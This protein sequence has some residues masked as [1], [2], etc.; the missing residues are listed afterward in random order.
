[1]ST[2]SAND[3]YT[4]LAEQL[5]FS[6]SKRFR[7]ILENLMTPDQAKMAAALPGTAADVADKTGFDEALIKEELEA[8]FFKGVLFPRGDFSKREFYRFTR[9][10]GQFH[11]SSM[12]HQDLDIVKDA[13]LFSLW[14]D[15]CVEEY[16]E[17]SGKR[18]A[19]NKVA[20]TR[21]VPSYMALKDV[22]KSDILPCEDFRELIKA[23]DLIVVV[24]CPCR[25]RTASVGEACEH[26]DEV[27]R[28]NCIQFGRAAEYVLARGSGKKLS[29]QEALDLVDEVEKD[30]LIHLWSN[31]TAMTGM[32][33][34]CQCCEDCCISYV[35]MRVVDESIGHVWE[36]ARFEAFI[37]QSKC[38]GCQDC[39]ERCH[40]D[41]ID[42]VK[43]QAFNEKKRT[44]KLK[45]IIEPD[46]CWG[47]GVCV[48]GCE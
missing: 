42:M 28:W 20:G 37:D 5:G 27:E 41:A 7:A 48:I 23:Q 33:F 46:K 36:K 44:K 29:T 38:D 39:V 10:V 47:C 2:V 34:S 6:E 18:S 25:Y 43:P 40:F 11:D 8:L 32:Y 31:S 1:M 21:V 15:F 19:Q 22:P 24:P 3:D 26:C 4:A 30:G 13:E 9:S 35:P 14:H 17:I 12:A 16:Y 45:A